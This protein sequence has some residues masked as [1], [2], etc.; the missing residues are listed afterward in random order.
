MARLREQFY[1]RAAG[2]RDAE[3][4]VELT[5]LLSMAEGLKPPRFDVGVFLR[6]GCAA[7]PAFSVLLAEAKQAGIIGYLLHYP[8]Y[9]VGLGQ[10]GRH[11]AELFVRQPWRRCGVGSELVTALAERMVRLGESWLYWQTYPGNMDAIEFY[12]KLGA[13]RPAA[14]TFSLDQ[15]QLRGLSRLRS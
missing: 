8:G 1:I 12:E 5:K 3:S 7:N 9:D 11:L 6:D 15:E 13:R 2:P 10:R 14:I 4:V